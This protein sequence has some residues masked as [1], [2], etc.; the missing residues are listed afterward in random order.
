MA[1][2]A[3]GFL[4]LVIS[5]KVIRQIEKRSI[6]KINPIVQEPAPQEKTL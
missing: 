6:K 4:W 5:L 1:G 2:F 3:T